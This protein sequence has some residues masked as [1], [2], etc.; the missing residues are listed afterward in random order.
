MP[1][2]TG[3]SSASHHHAG[4]D[5]RIRHAQVLAMHE[6]MPLAQ[7][8]SLVCALA[9]AIV[10]WQR[11]DLAALLPWL[12]ARLAISLTRIWY[13]QACVRQPARHTD[14]AYVGLALIDTTIFSRAAA[15][16]RNSNWPE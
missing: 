16:S 6:V 1:S 14:R 5:T 12:A 8:A 3:V 13:S 15:R 2:S 9:V 11:V 10:L 4:V 7:C